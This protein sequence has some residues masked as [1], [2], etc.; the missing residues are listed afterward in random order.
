MKLKLQTRPSYFVER[1][2]WIS[3]KIS[4]RRVEKNIFELCW[5]EPKSLANSCLYPKV[6]Y[7]HKFE[8]HNSLKMLNLICFLSNLII[9]TMIKRTCCF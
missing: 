4:Q 3:M 9:E 8:D 5:I 1:P 6:N 7:F 2:L